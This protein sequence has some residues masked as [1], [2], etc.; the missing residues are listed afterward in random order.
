MTPFPSSCVEFYVYTETESVNQGNGSVNILEVLAKR[1]P[2]TCSRSCHR[3][4][5][6]S[7]YF[8]ND[9]TKECRLV[10]D[11]V[12]GIS[13]NV[14]DN[15]VNGEAGWK[16]IVKSMKQPSCPTSL[17]FHFYQ[18]TNMCFKML[19]DTRLSRDTANVLCESI[20]G[21]ILRIQ[22]DKQH[23]T[24]VAFM[25]KFHKGD[26]VIIDGYRNDPSGSDWKFSNGV[27]MT[28]FKWAEGQP[29]SGK[30]AIKMNKNRN[31][32]WSPSSNMDKLFLCEIPLN[33]I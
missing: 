17:G 20:G 4:P 13:G 2:L 33:D 8:E 19:S 24:T 3:N 15:N 6:C 7:A 22:N 31:F 11:N 14:T 29:E 9:L 23:A 12:T 5:Q 27:P 10:S 26:N 1:N 18:D 21:R 30:P 28:Y 16:Y 32:D 25:E